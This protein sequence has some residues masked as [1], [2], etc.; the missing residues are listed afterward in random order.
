MVM[1]IRFCNGIGGDRM[2]PEALREDVIT[3]Q[4]FLSCALQLTLAVI[5]IHALFSV[6]SIS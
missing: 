2:T 5:S 6:R 4:Y 1:E 3:E